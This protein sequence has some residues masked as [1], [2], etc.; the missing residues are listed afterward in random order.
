MSVFAFN[1]NKPP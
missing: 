1:H